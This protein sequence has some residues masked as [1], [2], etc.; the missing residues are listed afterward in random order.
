MQVP[1]PLSLLA[2]WTNSGQAF[3]RK[4]KIQNRLGQLKVRLQRRRQ[5]HQQVP[6]LAPHRNQPPRHRE[7]GNPHRHALRNR[8]RLPSPPRLP[9]QPA[10]RASRTNQPAP[11]DRGP[12]D[13]AGHRRCP[14]RHTSS[15]P[16][17]GA[18]RYPCPDTKPRTDRYRCPDGGADRNTCPTPT[19]APTE[20]RVHPDTNPFGN[21]VPIT[22]NR[23]DGPVVFTVTLVVTEWSARTLGA[24]RDPELVT[25]HRR[26][27]LSGRDFQ[28]GRPEC[29]RIVHGQRNKLPLYLRVGRVLELACPGSRSRRSVTGPSLV[30]CSGCRSLLGCCAIWVRVGFPTQSLAS[31][32]IRACM[33]WTAVDHFMMSHNTNRQS[34]QQYSG[35]SPPS[36]SLIIMI[37]KSI[38]LEYFCTRDR[39]MP[40]TTLDCRTAMMTR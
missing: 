4:P 3:C 18:D 36:L 23:A 27:G 33:A 29:R 39:I 26:F 1:I 35:S 22:H 12:N 28:R 7:L 40:P 15:E 31:A 14:D 20:T 38:L 9:N 10:D 11:A 8:P 25:G 24:V 34:R 30:K 37:L 5:P 21:R 16:D 32:P 13:R 2:H 6:E 19:V 17:S